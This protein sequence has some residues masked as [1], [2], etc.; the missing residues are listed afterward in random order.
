MPYVITTSTHNYPNGSGYTV[1]TRRAVATLD[2]AR[3]AAELAVI[4]RHRASPRPWGRDWQAEADRLPDSGGTV[5]PLP[6][7][8]VIGVELVGWGAF[9]DYLTDA[10]KL[11]E[12]IHGREAEVIAA[13]NAAHEVRASTRAE[14]PRCGV[15]TVALAH[16]KLGLRLSPVPET[17]TPDMQGRC[18]LC[19]WMGPLTDAVAPA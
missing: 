15:A 3:S 12:P 9:V 16:D 17:V 4:E 11:S 5:G 1:H 14:C 8:T 7:G 10:E 13:Y 2:E 6:D 18:S 19:E